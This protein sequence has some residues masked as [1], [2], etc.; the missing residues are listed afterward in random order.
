MN[1]EFTI[2]LTSAGNE[3][4]RA[5]SVRAERDGRARRAAGASSVGSEGG[6]D[7]EGGGDGGIE[8]EGR[9]AGGGG[10]WLAGSLWQLN[11][12]VNC[13]GMDDVSTCNT[14]QLQQPEGDW[15][16]L[17]GFRRTTTWNQRLHAT[18]GGGGA[19]TAATEPGGEASCGRQ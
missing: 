14:T 10:A 12:A 16:D 15:F 13:S 17:R 4:G 1:H 11:L 8:G 2:R 3:R 18:G 5:V 7:D 6:G 19:G 9:S